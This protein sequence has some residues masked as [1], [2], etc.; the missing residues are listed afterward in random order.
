MSRK[1]AS[2]R[3]DRIRRERLE[4]ETEILRANT[5][6]IFETVL[7]YPGVYSLG[8]ASLPFQSVFNQLSSWPDTRCERTFFPDKDEY[9]W[10]RRA[11]R[12]IVTLE[13]G[14]Q[15]GESDLLVFS[16]S[17]ETDCLAV[18]EMMHMS[19]ITLHSSRRTAK[20]PIII[21]TGLSV[22][23]NPLPLSPFFDA[24]LIGES[25]PSLGPVLDTIK[26]LGYQ[27]APK[28]R[29]LEWLA[30]LP[31]VYVPSVH[32]IVR[33]KAT[34]I[35]Q[36]AGA[37]SIGTISGRISPESPIGDM[38][39]MELARGCP[40]NCRFCM[41]GYI[42]LPY[43]EKRLED[44]AD[45]IGG[46]PKGSTIGVSAS[47]P[48]SFTCYAEAME[49]IGS[50][51]FTIRIASHAVDTVEYIQNIWA[52]FDPSVINLNLEAGSESLRKVLG[53]NIKDKSVLEMIAGK[54]RTVREINIGFQVGLPFEM[55]ADRN[56]IE[57]L[58]RKIRRLTKLSIKVHIRPFI[59]RP[60]TAFQWSAMIHPREL[61]RWIATVTEQLGAITRV[62]VTSA[63]PRDAHILALLARGDH[64]TAVALEEKL[65]GVGWNTAFT[66]AEIDINWVFRP[67]KP[68]TPFGW[69]F[70]NMGFGYTRLARELQ[71]ALSA[72][73][74]RIKESE[75]TAQQ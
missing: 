62:T 75:E 67:L 36:W 12:P 8:M 52:D 25:E 47:S 39:L 70:L 24:F 19:G 65:T 27:G 68:G 5:G 9:N 51:D 72:N 57:Q 71:L 59:P 33:P 60:W 58:V 44:L 74:A 37:D 40:F 41:P 7:G 3:Y 73:L 61:R 42:Y 54:D 53:K 64:R 16:V 46:I 43:R 29:I 11:E 69:D 48:S 14:R 23:A 35:R 10:R 55:E 20:W 26:S 63:S 22:T 13:S 6:G 38:V 32:G 1:P 45:I 15:I 4:R 21:A 31:G 50:H 34:I 49:M 30:R 56:A 17:F 2:E 18:L 66:K 28:K